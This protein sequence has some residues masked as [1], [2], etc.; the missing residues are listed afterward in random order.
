[1][2]EDGSL[3]VSSLRKE[4]FT[5]QRSACARQMLASEKGGDARAY[6]WAWDCAWGGRHPGGVLKVALE[7]NEGD[8][9]VAAPGELA[10]SCE[11]AEGSADNDDML[12]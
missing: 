1:L 4:G 6:C 2:R 9:D 5:K 12:G 7:V 10:L 8:L 3:Q 11:A